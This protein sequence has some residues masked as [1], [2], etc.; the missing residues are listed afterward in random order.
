MARFDEPALKIELSSLSLLRIVSK[1]WLTVLVVFIVGS[2]SCIALVHR[3]KSTYRSEA[4]ILLDSRGISERYVSSS[5]DIQGQERLAALSQ[6]ILATTRLLKIIDT[7]GLYRIPG[8]QFATEDLVETMRK[9][10]YMKIEKVGDKDLPIA[11]HVGYRAH[12]PR[13]A[14]QVATQ[15]ADAFIE[16]NF[17]VRERQAE[18]TSA[19]IDVQLAD[20]RATLSRAEEKLRTYKLLH[21]GFLPEQEGALDTTLARLQVELQGTQDTMNRLQQDKLILFTAIQMAQSGSGKLAKVAVQNG[22]PNDQ[23]QERD[24]TA[25]TARMELADRELEQAKADHEQILK[26][27]TQ[28]QARVEQIPLRALELA[29]LNRDFEIANANYR[30]LLDKKVAAGMTTD[31]E[32]QQQGDRFTMVDAPRVPEKPIGPKRLLLTSAGCMLSLAFGLGVAIFQDTRKNAILGDWEL[33]NEVP[34][35]GKVPVLSMDRSIAGNNFD[36]QLGNLKAT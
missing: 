30:S 14:A 9:D 29:P 3:L 26:S 4:L 5:A 24:V 28:Y 6:Q 22:G 17:K 10:I 32:R 19:F 31:M 2:S 1:R 15:L 36:S 7:L 25:L 11:F 16:E 21:Y 23:A 33:G 18:G 13:L 12:D 35:L 34:L 8:K 27:M 20:A